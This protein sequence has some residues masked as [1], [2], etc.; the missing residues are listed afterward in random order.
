[1]GRVLVIDD[2]PD[3]ATALVDLLGCIPG[4]ALAQAADFASGLHKVGN[5]AWD[6]VIADERLP[7]GSGTELLR[8]CWRLRPS[9]RRVLMT[10]FNDVE[11]SV[12]AINE[13]RAH[14]FVEKPWDPEVV[15]GT[16]KELLGG[17]RGTLQRIPP[18][19]GGWRPAP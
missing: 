5:E 14:Y 6:V 7:D 11:V 18:L 17:P 19:P 4:I 15:L 10:A 2:E 16:V 13:G 8:E 1:V 3:V 12:R 9:T